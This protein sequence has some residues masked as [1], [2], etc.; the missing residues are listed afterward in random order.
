MLIQSAT[1]LESS[2]NNSHTKQNINTIPNTAMMKLVRLLRKNTQK[3]LSIL[4]TNLEN[5]K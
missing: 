1:K 5:E 4:V 2:D 3:T